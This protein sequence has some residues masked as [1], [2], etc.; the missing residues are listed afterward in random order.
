MA[1]HDLVRPAG[2]PGLYLAV[3][4]KGEPSPLLPESDEDTGVSQAAPGGGRAGGGRVARRRPPA[5]PAQPRRIDTPGGPRAARTGDRA[6]RPRRPGSADHRDSRRAR[7]TTASSRPARPGPCSTSRPRP[8]AAG[9]RR[10]G[11]RR[12][13]PPSLPPERPPSGAVRDRRHRLRRDRGRPEARV[14]RW[15]AGRPGAAAPV[16]RRQARASSWWTPTGRPHKQAREADRLAADVP[17]SEGGVPPDLQRGQAPAA[18][19]LLRAEH[20][21]ADWPK[22]RRCTACSCRMSGTAPT[23]TT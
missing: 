6:D 18:R 22:M 19:L 16:A 20:H 12:K 15:A 8:R 10:A 17:R 7:A 9:R 3:L 5:K 4:K 1:G 23:S 21:G 2:D 14:P 11:R 13:C